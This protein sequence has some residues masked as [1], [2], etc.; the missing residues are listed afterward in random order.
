MEL[1][2]RAGGPL[3]LLDAAHNPAKCEA[4][5]QAVRQYFPDRKALLVL[6]A[7]ADKNVEAMAGPL[8]AVSDQVWV[9]T[10][11]SPRRL[12][13]EEMATLCARLGRT[14]TAEPSVPAAVEQAL[15]AAGPSDLVVITGSFYT[16]G[17]ARRHLL[18]HR[19][20]E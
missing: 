4:L 18:V 10:P 14:V 11:E 6:G 17:P 19:G 8:L 20:Q 3:I 1:L 12:P 5:A 2:H 13:A 9:T 7:L 15:A 16:V